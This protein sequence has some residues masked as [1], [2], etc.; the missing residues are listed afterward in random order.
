METL[1][2]KPNCP[3]SSLH[4]R[5]GAGFWT[6]TCWGRVPGASATRQGHSH[7]PFPLVPCLRESTQRA[8]SDSGKGHSALPTWCPESTL[9]LGPTRCRPPP[10]V[11]LSFLRQPGG[12]SRDPRIPS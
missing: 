10:W 8:E 11:V 3:L 7:A 2:S 12:G 1:R 6:S 5:L 9:W 4:G